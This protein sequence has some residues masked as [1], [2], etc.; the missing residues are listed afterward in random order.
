MRPAL[1]A[2]AAAAFALAGGLAAVAR[3]DDEPP[4][5][6]EPAKTTEP[7]HPGV[8]I[9]GRQV[10][11]FRG[12]VEVGGRAVTG[13]EGRYE[14]D[15]NLDGGF[16]LFSAEIEGNSLEE[17][18]AIDVL[19]F[20]LFGLG[21]PMQSFDFR[22]AAKEFYDL[23]FTST[24]E[25]N[26]YRA[27]RDPHP[28]DTLRVRDAGSLS[29]HLA[30]RFEIHL[31][32]E[33]L[34]RRGD[35]VLDQY[36]I[37]RSDYYP[38]AADIDFERRTHTAGFDASSGGFRFGGTGDWTGATDDALRTLDYSD[39][40]TRSEG[41]YRNKSRITGRGFTGRAGWKSAGGLLDLSVQG[42]YRTSESDTEIQE[43]AV[44]LITGAPIPYWTQVGTSEANARSRWWRGEAL[45]APAEGFEILGRW[46]ETSGS[47][48]G[49]AD[50]TVNS[51]ATDVFDTT[52][53]ATLR[54]AGL[55]A[56]WR[57]TNAWRLRAGAE[58]VSERRTEQVGATSA[59]D[60][61]ADVWAPSTLVGT[62]GVD[63]R[64]SSAL[65]ASLLA[66]FAAANDPAT[67]LSTESGRA[68]SFRLRARPGA[69][70]HATGFARVKQRSTEESDS[71][72]D[73]DSYGLSVGR[74]GAGGWFE[75]SATREEFVL[76][77]D[78]VVVLSTGLPVVRSPF[79]SEYAE[80]VDSATLDFSVVV[81]GPLRCFGNARWGEG[82]GDIPYDQ[83]D[84]GAG[85]GWRF[86][87]AAEF[88]IEARRVS[89]KEPDRGVDDY[90][91][92]IYTFSILWEF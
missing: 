23:R 56:N 66:R 32:T 30:E 37:P 61:D 17:G 2:I 75:L 5:V 13:K 88:R 52:A 4:P 78:S 71:M 70:W 49:D 80:S 92:S 12:G 83:L 81:S 87:P 33:R 68:L 91:A 84:A 42:G 28:L 79:R 36:Y 43:D 7:D 63:F 50:S 48:V 47:V 45:L 14:Q 65:D 53:D 8:V 58:Q 85:L 16:R 27:T 31:S 44:E 41:T 39:A 3:A 89:Y 1:P 72:V 82:D 86:V 35:G 21:D 60:R 26:V 24:R 29:V 73:Y 57:A 64:P 19:S 22:A 62:A 20:R 25:E 18:M 46:E 76:E 11:D 74:E 40:A 34:Q 67:A 55:E 69:G 59:S 51:A 10:M 54:R 15:V 9:E 38:V 6:P 90:S 77:A